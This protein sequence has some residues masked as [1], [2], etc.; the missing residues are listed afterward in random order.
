LVWKPLAVITS[1]HWCNRGAQL[2]MLRRLGACPWSLPGM[3]SM[4]GQLCSTR[5][6]GTLRD[7]SGAVCWPAAAAAAAAVLPV[8]SSRVLLQW[9]QY[10]RVQHNRAGGSV[11][12]RP[13]HTHHPGSC[14]HL[15]VWAGA[16][17]G[18]RARAVQHHKLVPDYCYPCGEC[19]DPS[20]DAGHQ[21]RRLAGQ[22]DSPQCMPSV[23]G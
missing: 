23:H 11:R 10:S 21:V 5:A 18:D 9:L 15:C 22:L 17:A 14:G 3:P 6:A 1:H 7:C 16:A 2:C 8:L 20:G 13:D 4:Q 12:R 19:G